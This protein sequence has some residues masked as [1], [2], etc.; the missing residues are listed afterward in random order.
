MEKLGLLI[1]LLAC[2]CAEPAVKQGIEGLDD[3]YQKIVMI[4][5]CEY[6]QTGIFTSNNYSLTHKGNCKF[7][8]Q[9]YADLLNS[10]GVVCSDKKC[11]CHE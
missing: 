6:I 10:A 7:C 2:S 8:L 9:R 1:M 11:K 3:N 5:S 4:D